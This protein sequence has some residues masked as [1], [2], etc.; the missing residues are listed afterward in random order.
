VNRLEHGGELALGIEIGGRRNAEAAGER[1]G[2]RAGALRRQMQ[3]LMSDE[4]GVFRTAEGMGRAV[5]GLRQLQERYRQVRVDDTGKVFN[6]DLLEAWEL[7]C[8]LDVAEVTAVAA[9]ARKES[10]GAHARE[11]YPKRDDANWM[12]HSFAFLEDGGLRLA[13]KPVTVTR[14]EAKERVY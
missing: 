14:F 11:D 1:G 12:K 9:L 13:Y 3:K 4:V 7:G 10:R 5:D 2:E 6:T 8:L